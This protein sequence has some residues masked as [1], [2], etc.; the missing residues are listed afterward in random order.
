MIEDVYLAGAVRTPI[1]AFGGALADVPAPRLGAI[2]VEGALNAAGV[3]ADAVDE[4]VMG[5]VIGAGLGQNVARQCSL[6]AGSA[7]PVSRRS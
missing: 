4:V 3:N 5:N 7:V 2:A 1:G 6:G